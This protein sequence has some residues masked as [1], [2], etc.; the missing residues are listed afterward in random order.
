VRSKETETHKLSA[1]YA[2]VSILVL[3]SAMLPSSTVAQTLLNASDL[4]K[5]EDYP[6]G[7]MNRG[8]EGIAA[9]E[10]SFKNGRQANC[11]I[12]SSSGFEE[13]DS[14]TCRLVMERSSFD[15]STL[16]KGKWPY[17]YNR[18]RWSIRPG[19]P[20]LPSGGLF[21]SASVSRVDPDK[22]RCQYSDG[23]VQFVHTF[24]PCIQAAVV[25]N[26]QSVIRV[27]GKRDPSQ[28]NAMPVT[29]APV[30]VRPAPLSENIDV[31]KGGSPC[32][33][34]RYCNTIHA[35]RLQD[36]Y[37]SSATTEAQRTKMVEII[38]ENTKGAATDWNA[39]AGSYFFWRSRPFGLLSKNQLCKDMKKS[40]K[41][42]SPNYSYYLSELTTRGLTEKQCAVQWGKI[43]LA[44]GAV[45]VVAAAASGGG[46]GSYGSAG[47]ED[48]TFRWDE[49]PGDFGVGRR[50]VCR[51]EQT[52]QYA[53]TTRC[54]GTIKADTRW[55]G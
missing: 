38:W 22:N 17:Y 13:L 54:A 10:L 34:R 43:F 23:V 48:V 11:R 15:M 37:V 12:T 19:E 44:V 16:T 9:Y 55:P 42:A 6:A 27:T 3:A 53:E 33:T 18:V 45:A 1:C 40:R 29:I 20:R 25:P 36:A 52:G 47:T 39:A 24:S 49:Q 4:I 50:W 8:E 26:Q 31:Y 21:A 5:S 30:A 28:Q 51:G 46:G 14:A 7:S 35:T 41:T 2:S 32:G